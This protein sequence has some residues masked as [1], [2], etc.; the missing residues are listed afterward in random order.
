MYLPRL[1]FPGGEIFSRA[2]KKPQV[3]ERFENEA[4]HK[5]TVWFDCA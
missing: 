3:E 4:L 5:A 1:E 2:L